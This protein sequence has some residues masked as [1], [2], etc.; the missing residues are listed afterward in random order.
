MVKKNTELVEA[1]VRLSSRQ[2]KVQE[3]EDDLTKRKSSIS[4]LTASLEKE[5]VGE[6]T[7]NNVRMVDFMDAISRQNP[8]NWRRRTRPL[9]VITT[10]WNS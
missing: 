9:L 10:S 5:A 4:D 1:G 8:A 6:M 2:G 7:D 3:L